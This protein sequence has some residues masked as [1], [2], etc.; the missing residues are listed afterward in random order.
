LLATAALTTVERELM[1]FHHIALKDLR[2][3]LRDRNALVLMLFL[4]LMLTAIIGFAFGSDSGISTIEFLLVGPEG[5]EFVLSALAG[6][7]NHMDAFEVATATEAEARST[8]GAGQKVAAVVLPAG[9][10][11][12]ILGGTPAT[13]VVLA[14]PASPIKAGIVKAIVA[15]FASYASAGSVLARGI[16]EALEDERPLT[17][18]ERWTLAR[19]MFEWMRDAW[20]DLPISVE[21]AD[22]EARE[23]DLKAYFAPSFAVLFLLFTMLASAKTIHEERESGTYE[24]LMTAP[25]SRATFVGG[26][27]LG[28]YLLAA[29]QL[30]SFLVLA[31]LL[32]GIHWGS[33][34]GAAAAMALATAA[35][36][37]SLALLIG[38]AARTA[39]QTD[40]VG[41]AVVLVMSLVG[42]GMWPIEHAPASFQ[43][44]AR[45]TFNYWAHSGF[46]ELV[47]DDAGLLGISQEI[48]V[49]TAMS[50]VSFVLAARL[51]ARR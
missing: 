1:V 19:W 16:F 18:V 27:F 37:S 10:L 39:R 41:T 25:V 12:A 43:R 34:P 7:I 33:H 26:K 42:G 48:A 28:T 5:S 4:P 30:L 51:L 23:F 36:A 15:Q 21:D 46:R 3:R 24:R 29:T 40:S 9:L 50:A 38:A 49:I 11:D 22:T 2:I 17:D 20:E 35:G 45:F 47:F 8:V 32:F 13:I 44:L 14:D 6:V 31:S